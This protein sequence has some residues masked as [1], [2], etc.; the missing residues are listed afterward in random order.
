MNGVNSEEG[1]IILSSI[2]TTNISDSFTAKICN[3]LYKCI[4]QI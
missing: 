4:V 1:Y 3:L 2:T